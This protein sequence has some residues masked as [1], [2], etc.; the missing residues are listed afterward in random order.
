MRRR[1]KKL[2]TREWRDTNDVSNE[3]GEVKFLTSV[4]V[5]DMNEAPCSLAPRKRQRMS[6]S[7][8]N[9]KQQV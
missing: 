1:K 4:A 7:T 3:R 9:M 8:L 5:H 6:A 2:S